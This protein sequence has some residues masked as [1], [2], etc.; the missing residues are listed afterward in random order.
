MKR[1]YHYPNV[2]NVAKILLDRNY[3]DIEH[4]VK[5]RLKTAPQFIDKIELEAELKGHNGCVNCLE[6][7]DNGRV[8]ASASDDFHVMLWDPFS[9]KKLYDL[10]TPHD[11]NIFSVKFLPKRN[12][13]TLVTGAGDC[14]TFVFD[15][16]RGND[17]PIR[18]CTCHGQRVKR[19]ATSSKHV[20]LFW[21]SA[22][23]GKVLQH[24][25]RTPHTCRANDANVLINLRNH[26]NEMPEV[27]CIAINPQRPELMAI[28]ANDCYARL[29]DRRMLSLM[30][31]ST[32]VE[33]KPN[34]NNTDNVPRDGCV[35][36]YCPGHLSRNKDTVYSIFNQ[37]AVTYL[38]FSPDGGELLVNMG[39]EQ[40][41][42]YDLARPKEPMFLQLPK[43]TEPINGTNGTTTNGE[44]IRHKLPPEVE[45]MKKEGNA[46]LEKEMYLQA[47]QQYTKAIRKAQE[48]DC[49]ILYL[50]RATALMK[51]NWYGDVYAA[52]RDCHRALR[53]DPHYVKAHF[54][55][56][57]ALLKLGQLSNAASCLTE[58]VQRF[59][60]YA[61]NHGVLMLD[62]DIEAELEKQRQ[63]QRERPVDSETDQ[64]SD[65]ELA[66]RASALDY[67]D[68]FVGHC[69]TKTDI[70]EA[71]YFGD[72]NYIV[73]GS[74]DGNFFIWE[75]DSG[76]IASIY[77]ADELIVN[78]VQPH[79]FVCLLATSGIDHEVRLWSPQAFESRLKHRIDEVVGTVNE[80]Q[81]RMQSDPFDSLAPDQAMCRAS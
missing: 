60:S 29:Y 56:A 5:N 16:N 63:R 79:P 74:D 19:L 30:K 21:S 44:K 75:R 53:L 38:T 46:N 9:H 20:H 51:R 33:L 23:D 14:R 45:R 59:P 35:Q 26:I 62:K 67:Q 27:K 72:S 31:L 12:N 2:T 54:R 68:R 32:N 18:K 37:K 28:G 48:K 13:S 10:V 57:R 40:I 73:A 77:Q 15:I 42:L 36:Y 47:I 24:D 81:N 22:E 55:L 69:N 1:K 43:F 76:M 41:Y 6:W 4:I 78:S 8:L 50:N 70:K 52:V 66:W 34:E 7:S 58:L 25:M 17:F 64:F 11:G 49:S 3:R 80:N 39:S 61:K 71:N 65:N